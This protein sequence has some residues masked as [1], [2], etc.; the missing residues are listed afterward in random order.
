M[1][2]GIYVR[3]DLGGPIVALALDTGDLPR[4]V[5]RACGSDDLVLDSGLGAEN[6][7]ACASCPDGDRSRQPSTATAMHLLRRLLS[8]PED[9]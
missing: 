4:M 9:S 1:V 6:S 5:D 7:R 2:I 8:D 3:V